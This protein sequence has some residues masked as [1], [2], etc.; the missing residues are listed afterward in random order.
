M[1]MLVLVG[2]I[3]TLAIVGNGR[4]VDELIAM[5]EECGWTVNVMMLEIPRKASWPKSVG[6]LTFR[7][8]A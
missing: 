4:H 5:N 8:L 1:P 7:F 2:Y 6:R 3:A